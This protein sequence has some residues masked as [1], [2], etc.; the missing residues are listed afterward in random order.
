MTAARICTGLI[1]F[2]L[3]VTNLIERVGVIVSRPVVSGLQA[4]WD[5]TSPGGVSGTC[6][7]WDGQT[8]PIGILP[9]LVL[10]DMCLYCLREQEQPPTPSSSR[11]AGGGGGVV[12]RSGNV[13][14]VVPTPSD[15]GSDERRG[16]RIQ[17]ALSHAKLTRRSLPWAYTYSCWDQSSPPRSF[18]C[19]PPPPSLRL[20]GLHTIYPCD[21]S[22]ILS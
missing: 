19:R 21:S 5:S 7:D 3:E 12:D 9:A 18:I 4:G 20:T 11:P 6:W 17:T 15:R 8:I 1:V 14:K 22:D 16:R 2:V 10:A 13:V